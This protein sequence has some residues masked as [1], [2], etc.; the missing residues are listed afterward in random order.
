MRRREVG[1]FIQHDAGA[2]QG[3]GERRQKVEVGD[4]AVVEVEIVDAPLGGV[5][6]DGVI[7]IA[8]P[9]VGAHV[10]AVE[11]A[12]LGID[13]GEIQAQQAGTLAQIHH[14]AIVVVVAADAGEAIAEVDAAGNPPR[15]GAGVAAAGRE[16]C[17][18]CGRAAGRCAPAT[19]L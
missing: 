3:I 4:I 1:V 2:E 11:E 16:L 18:G 6:V 12:L 14:A 7:G 19:E 15:W 8:A 17:G 13:D 10:E 9:V 5:H